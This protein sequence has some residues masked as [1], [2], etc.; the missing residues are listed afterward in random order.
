LFIAM[1]SLAARG[2]AWKRRD[3]SNTPSTTAWL[4]PMPLK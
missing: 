4:T 3:A 2:I 1:A